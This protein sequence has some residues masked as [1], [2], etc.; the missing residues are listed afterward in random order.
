MLPDTQTTSSGTS[1]SETHITHTRDQLGLAEVYWRDRQVWLEAQGYML[2]PRYH[3]NWVPSW[4]DKSNPDLFRIEDSRTLGKGDRVIDATRISDGQMVM[5]KRISTQAHPFEVEITKYFSTEPLSS[6]PRNHS[7]PLIDVLRV[8]DEDDTVIL[9]MPLLHRYE[10]PRFLTVGECVEF[11]R[12]IFEGLQFMHQCH[13][14]HRDCMNLNI[15]MDPKPLFPDMY[16][17]ISVRMKKD[18]SGTAKHYTRTAHPVK[19][20][21]I[22]FGISRKYSPD[23]PHP[24]EPPIRGGDK[25]VPEFQRSHQPRDPFPTDIYYLGNLIR[26]DFLETIGVEFMAPLVADMMQADPSKR[27]TIDEVVQR[28]E[29]IRRSL[30][31][32]KLRSRLI[33]KRELGYLITFRSV[34]HYIRTV[35]YVLTLKS[36]VP[37]PRTWPSYI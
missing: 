26:E 21:F 3:P 14:A 29:D 1:V 7:V 31:W 25:T 10:T 15:M 36:A 19:Y 37:T 9:V 33:E 34:K 13:V 32:W 4:K 2:R 28:F 6:H 5:L 30:R 8:P 23:N 20:Y 12:Q 22:D 18:L 35:A 16:H 24:L 17:P 27:P 11:F